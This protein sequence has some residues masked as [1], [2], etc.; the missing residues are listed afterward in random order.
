MVLGNW[1]NRALPSLYRISLTG[2]KQTQITNPAEKDGDFR[3][4]IVKNHL[5]WIRTDRKSA[6]VMLTPTYKSRE[7]IWIKNINLGSSYYEKWS[8]DEVFSLYTG[9]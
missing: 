8:W 2:N 1:A 5:F 4:E 3:P 7:R 9:R 6:D